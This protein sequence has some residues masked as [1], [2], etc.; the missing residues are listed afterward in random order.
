MTQVPEIIAQ[1]WINTPQPLSLDGLRGKIVVI[2]A[3]QMLCPGCVSHGLPLAQ[4]IQRTF[5]PERVE[6]LGLHCVFEHHD[7]MQK[8]AL[9]AFAHEYRL[10]FPIAIDQPSLS[11]PLPMTM[12]SWGLR[13]TPSLLIV[14]ADG[15]ILAHHFGQ[16]SELVVGAQIGAALSALPRDHHRGS[17]ALE[18]SC[19]ELGCPI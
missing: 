10:T 13:G 15:A 17:D 7:A 18:A 8:A 5:E 12:Q 1:D 3:F 6:V 19:T 14:G 16:V 9:E 2:E 11:N 4:S